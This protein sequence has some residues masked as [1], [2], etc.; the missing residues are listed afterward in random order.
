[1]SKSFSLNIITLVNVWLECKQYIIYDELP[2]QIRNL[3]RL[4]L[5]ANNY[6]PMRTRYIYIYC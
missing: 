3:Q 2:A 6:G 1:M 4:S 5:D